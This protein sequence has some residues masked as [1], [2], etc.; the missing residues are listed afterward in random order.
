MPPGALRV[1]DVDYRAPAAGLGGLLARLVQEPAD[2]PVPI[3][4]E[5]AL[6]LIFSRLGAGVDAKVIELLLI[7]D[8]ARIIPRTDP[9]GRC[10]ESTTRAWGIA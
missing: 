7:K 4:P 2:P 9:D 3:P 1:S 5:V 10:T 6:E 8:L